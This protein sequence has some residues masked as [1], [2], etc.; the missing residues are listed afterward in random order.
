V[1]AEVLAA[2]ALVLGTAMGLQ[3]VAAAAV[4]VTSVVAAAEVAKPIAAMT[5]HP[6]RK[7]ARA[8]VGLHMAATYHIRACT[9]HMVAARI[10]CFVLSAAAVASR[11]C[12]QTVM[13]VVAAAE[14][15]PPGQPIGWMA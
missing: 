4:A 11:P 1:T 8:T 13:T 9:W 15:I 7:A 6:P 5:P 3:L 10:R 14:R 2:A 12:P